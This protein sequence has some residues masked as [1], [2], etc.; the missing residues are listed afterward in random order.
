MNDV[1]T[2][3]VSSKFPTYKPAVAAVTVRCK[4]KECGYEGYAGRRGKCESL[5]FI[6]WLSSYYCCAAC[7]ESNIKAVVP[8]V[9]QEKTRRENLQL[10]YKQFNDEITRYRDYEWKII[11][12]SLGLSWGTFL[13]SKLYVT[14]WFL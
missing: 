8:E 12:W 14:L 13:A 11:L 6:N 3:V 10:L 9:E 4:A 1:S 2:P 5:P 7:G